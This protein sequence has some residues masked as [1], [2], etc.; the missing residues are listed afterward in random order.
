M[1]LKL[2]EVA[3]SEEFYEVDLKRVKKVEVEDV[4]YLLDV[5]SLFLLFL[6]FLSSKLLIKEKF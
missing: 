3:G 2:L 4:T 1:L 5:S 6:R